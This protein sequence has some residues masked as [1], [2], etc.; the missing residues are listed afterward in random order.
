[1]SKKVNFFV[2]LWDQVDDFVLEAGRVIVLSAIPIIAEAILSGNINWQLV[3]G[4]LILAALRALDRWL[5]EKGIL[6]K[7]LTQF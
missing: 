5:H 4:A 7:G 1:M 3:G 2:V 6:E